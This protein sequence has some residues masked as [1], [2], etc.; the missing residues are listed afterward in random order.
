MRILL[1]VVLLVA[2]DPLAWAAGGTRTSIEIILDASFTMN[3]QLEN[4]KKKLDVAKESI[5]YLMDRLD[6]D[7]SISLRVYGHLA[8]RE[9]QDCTD[10]ELLVPFASVSRNRSKAARMLRSVF[11]RGLSPLS[12]VLREAVHD[13]SLQ[14]GGRKII[15]LLA[16]GPCSC[17][18]DP[19]GVSWEEQVV[20]NTIGVRCSGQARGQLRC[21]AS[22]TGGRFFQVNDGLEL[23]RALLSAATVSGQT[24]PLLN[25]D[26]R[27]RIEGVDSNSV[28]VK[29]ADRQI[30][31]EFRQDGEGCIVLPAGV[32]TVS[33]GMQD[34]KSVMVAGG[35]TTVLEPGRLQVLNS[36]NKGHT[37]VEWESRRV[38]GTVSADS[39]ELTLLPGDYEVMFGRAGWRVK[40]PGVKQTVLKPGIIRV[41]NISPKGVELRALP[42]NTIVGDLTR[43]KNWMPLPPGEYL[44]DI[45]GQAFPCTLVED[46]RLVLKK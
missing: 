4:G 23:R 7:A 37:V 15:I 32:Y 36:T 31:V 26:G 34:W 44:V 12:R 16:D 8:L 35:R 41:E 5:L 14:P 46:Q 22:T 33:I 17:V 40:V 21:V 2:W 24:A 38:V 27:L 42:Q 45:E 11:P 39:P 25:G 43:K 9:L 29:R 3:E 10:S 19:C 30:E 18:G 6:G 28:L 20:V 1:A 13:L